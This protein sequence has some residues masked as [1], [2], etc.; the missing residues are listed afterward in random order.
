M[1]LQI[2]E[3]NRQTATA[4]FTADG[5]DELVPSPAFDYRTYEL[6]QDEAEDKLSLLIKGMTEVADKTGRFVYQLPDGRIID[7]CTYHRWEWPQAIG[8][9][10]LFDYYQLR[11]SQDPS[12][13][14]AQHTLA[15]MK[16]WYHQRVEEGIPT[17][18]INSMAVM[19]SVASLL[20]LDQQRG[21]GSLLYE[22]WRERFEGWVDEWAEWI[23]N[24]LPRTPQGGF[25]HVTFRL[26]N[27]GQLWDDTLMMTVI[28]L[29]KIGL[30]LNRPH[31]IEE[32][33]FQ[34]LLHTQYLMDEV[35]GFWYHAWRFDNEAG[36]SGTH[37]SDAPWARG[38][39][40][41]TL[42]IPMFLELTDLS[43]SD[44]VHRMLVSTLRRQVDAL[45]PL[46][47][48]ASG[49]WHTLLDDPTSYVETSGSSGFVGGILMAIRLGF[50]EREPY[51]DLAVSGLKACLA[52]I[53]PTGQ[54]GNVS[55]GTPA[56]KD[57]KFYKGIPRMGMV[58]GNS[59]LIV[60][61]VQ[62]MRLTKGESK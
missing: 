32:A 10:G 8:M 4:L 34:F 38:N 49:L 3:D 41:I 30:L 40:W 43:P 12:D 42:A 25:Q 33:K 19:Y 62:W 27:E 20:D 48:A 39:C 24:E 18:N 1:V 17:K 50:L 51:L 57:R 7:T 59:L 13:P 28:P 47:D 5:F 26:A 45:L 29:T 31:Y 6:D 46:R 23:M 58:Y 2:T 9:N 11:S 36:T 53:T 14:T 16:E 54:V 37:S 52:Q 44:P 61:L 56:G 35:S 55:K 60:A 21:K 22:E 15:L